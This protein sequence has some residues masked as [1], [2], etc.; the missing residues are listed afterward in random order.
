MFD[1][2]YDRIKIGQKY[3]TTLGNIVLVVGFNP[4]QLATDAPVRCIIHNKN[5]GKWTNCD[6]D[7]VDATSWKEYKEPVVH[8]MYMVLY[9]RQGLIVHNTIEKVRNHISCSGDIA[10]SIHQIRYEE[11]KEPSVARGDVGDFYRA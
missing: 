10:L 2:Q 8:K 7:Y 1:V 6:F 3:V 11:G 5:T 9:Q 4:V